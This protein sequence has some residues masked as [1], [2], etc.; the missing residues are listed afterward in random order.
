[1]FVIGA[2]LPSM[3]PSEALKERA[4]IDQVYPSWN[5]T[6]IWLEDV[7]RSVAY[8]WRAHENPFVD[9]ALTFSA[10]GRMVEEMR[11]R[12]GQWQNAE[13][14]AMKN[15]LIAL[16]A[17]S[18]NG[19]VSLASFYGG[20]DA[21]EEWQF[22]ESVGYL[23]QLG[24]LDE[25]NPARPRVLVANYISGPNNCLAATGL[26]SVCCIDE[27]E[28]LLAEVERGAAAPFAA[29]AEITGIVSRIP[30]ATVDAPR[31][32]SATLLGK[33]D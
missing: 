14:Q 22:T 29:P 2:D 32:L 19:R 3:T 15:K 26:H 6:K 27:C 21:G 31:N 8:A 12:Y 10:A 11:D 30:S 5:E 4:G 28:A 33:L 25:S 24:A 23:R 17:S 7:Q 9:G 16:D 18:G 20:V 1:M 13:C